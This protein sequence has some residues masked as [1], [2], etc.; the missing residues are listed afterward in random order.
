[1]RNLAELKHLR[2]KLGDFHGSGADKHRAALLHHQLHLIDNS[3][4]FLLL[5]AVDA[6]V[7]VVAYHRTVGRYLHH[8]ELVY[9]VELTSLGHCRTGHA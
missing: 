2:E 9:V 4:V 8:L 7:P 3:S 5:G 6:V 1:M